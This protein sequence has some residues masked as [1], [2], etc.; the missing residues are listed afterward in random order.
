MYIYTHDS[1]FYEEFAEMEG[2]QVQEASCFAW[3]KAGWE[4]LGDAGIR[5]TAL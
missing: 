3:G 1:Q 4:N 2:L 5:Q